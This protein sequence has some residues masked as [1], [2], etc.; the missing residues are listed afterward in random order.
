[1]TLTQTDKAIQED[2]MGLQVVKEVE[3][4]KFLNEV[5]KFIKHGHLQIVGLDVQK[6]YQNITRREAYDIVN[7]WTSYEDELTYD[8]FDDG[9]V[10]IYTDCG[11]EGLW[12]PC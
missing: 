12:T 9:S 3:K 8:E 5:K 2:L 6:D 11:I 1:M 7:Q 4:A 10:G